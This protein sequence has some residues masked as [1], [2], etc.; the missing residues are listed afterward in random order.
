MINPVLSNFRIDFGET[1]FPD[2]V[3]KKYDKFLYHKNYPFKTLRGYFYETIQ[4]MD[5]PGLNLNTLV[6]EALNNLGNNPQITDFPTPTINRQF[7]GTA[8]ENAIIEGTAVN[9]TFRNTVLNWMYC[10]EVLKRYYAR[11]R[12][13]K[14]FYILLTFMDSAEIPIIR[15]KFSD[16]F[17]SNLPGLSFAFNQSFSESKTFECG[18]TFNKMDVELIIPDFNISN[19]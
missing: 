11:T 17:A 19:L 18:F 12:T 1:F 15:F 7:P 5:I 16:C 2:E 10:Y 4:N 8:P 9:I 6:I 3:T 13:I 14:E